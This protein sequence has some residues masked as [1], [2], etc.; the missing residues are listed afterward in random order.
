MHIKMF[1]SLLLGLL[2][3]HDACAQIPQDAIPS[4]SRAWQAQNPVEEE[5]ILNDEPLPRYEE[6]IGKFAIKTFL[7]PNRSFAMKFFRKIMTITAIP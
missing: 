5:E 7:K 1:L 3:T 4:F 6:E 2:I